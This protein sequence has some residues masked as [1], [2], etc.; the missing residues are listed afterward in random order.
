MQGK[1]KPVIIFSVLQ[2]LVLRAG[3]TLALRGRDDRGLIPILSFVAKNMTN[4]RYSTLLIDVAH[5]ILGP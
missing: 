5:A 4:P 2:E 1:Y 3:L